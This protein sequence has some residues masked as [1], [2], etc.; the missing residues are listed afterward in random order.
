MKTIAVDES[1]LD[2]RINRYRFSLAHEL[3]HRVLHREILAEIEFETAA[4]WKECVTQVPERQYGFLEY[5]ANTFAN[6]L[7]VP[8]QQ[9]EPRFEQIIEKIR[10]AG[11]EP[12]E[13]PDV[14]LDTVSTELG[15]QFRVSPA[16]M[17]IRLEKDRRFDQL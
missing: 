6:A 17:R 16:T 9:L 11:L 7:L 14:C 10:A 2:N 13:Y 8:Q 12:K 15:K 3:G 5:Q 4:A 1:A